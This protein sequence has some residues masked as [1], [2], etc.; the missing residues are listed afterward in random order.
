MVET[1]IDQRRDIN[2]GNYGILE[3]K[4]DSG[5]KIYEFVMKELWLNSKIIEAKRSC[6]V[7]NTKKEMEAKKKRKREQDRLRKK[8]SKSCLMNS[9]SFH[10][11]HGEFSASSKLSK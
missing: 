1:Q 4:R 9:L 5:R 2:E 10:R 7:P 3:A 6:N 11:C 8:P